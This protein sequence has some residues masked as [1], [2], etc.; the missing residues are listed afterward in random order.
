MKY[1]AEYLRSL[2]DK[3]EKL[4]KEARELYEKMQSAEP[5]SDGY[6]EAR[7]SYDALRTDLDKADTDFREAQI[8]VQEAQELRDKEAQNLD[9]R[10]RIDNL[11][12]ENRDNPPDDT[13]PSNPTGS[14]DPA[15]NESYRLAFY[16]KMRDFAERFARRNGQEVR[17]PTPLTEEH[18]EVLGRIEHRL[19][20][21][22]KSSVGGGN[23]IPETLSSSVIEFM[24]FYGPM[25]PD[26]GLCMDFNTP[27]GADYKLITVDDTAN[28]AEL[29]TE[30]NRATTATSTGGSNVFKVG[31][32]PSFKQV[33]FSA[34]L[35]DSQII[36]ITVEMI[37]DTGLNDL[38]TLLGE[39]CG[40]RLG[41]KINADFTSEF[42]TAVKGNKVTA[43]AVSAFTA[44]E[45]MQLPHKIDPSY[46]GVGQGNQT[47]RL[48]V[49]FNDTV[50][51]TLR[52]MKVPLAGTANAGYT[53]T[54]YLISNGSDLLAGE[55][56]RLMGTY[57]IWLNSATDNATTGK[58]P[59][60]I[61]DFANAR[62]RS[63]LKPFVKV[64]EEH[65]WDRHML[66]MVALQRCDF[67]VV[68]AATFAALVMK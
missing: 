16:A 50:W 10:N 52:L 8:A 14:L 30:A 49:M 9:M 28:E 2:V 15:E 44:D 66:A 4:V 56:D 3:R 62:M 42:V 67:K 45:I 17:N 63:V 64:S 29:L 48:S 27:T 36:P 41:R 6:S 68:N 54:P 40:K 1:T 25:V 20:T 60:I 59:I 35:Y 47:N 5:D 22:V 12:P 7:T 34:H 26:G 61:G 46:R 24:K 43:A 37:M 38:E 57:P 65:Y 51:Q 19:S 32:D 55:P 39:L 11:H 18:R 31:A 13:P 33:T 58:V 21:G 23:T 53:A